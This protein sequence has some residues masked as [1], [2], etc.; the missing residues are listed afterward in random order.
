[1]IMLKKKSLWEGLKD[2]IKTQPELQGRLSEPIFA[3]AA[4]CWARSFP[5]SLGDVNQCFCLAVY[6]YVS[7]PSPRAPSPLLCPLQFPFPNPISRSSFSFVQSF[8]PRNLLDHHRRHSP[9]SLY[10]VADIFPA[11]LD[12]NK[13]CCFLWCRAKAFVSVT[14]FCLGNSSLFSVTVNSKGFQGAG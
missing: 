14:S 12:K 4:S 6:Q 5:L 11:G 3:G 1:M 10:S 7:T 13:F 9:R 2:R 8:F